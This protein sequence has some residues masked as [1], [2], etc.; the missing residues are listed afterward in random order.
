MNTVRTA[1]VREMRPATEAIGLH[2][3]FLIDKVAA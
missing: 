1:P 3:P 2:I